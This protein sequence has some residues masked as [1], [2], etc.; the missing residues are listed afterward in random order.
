MA[1]RMKGCQALILAVLAAALGLA[2][3]G[4]GGGAGSDPASV[5]PP[6]APLFVEATL[7]PEGQQ[8]ADVDALAKKIAGIDDL[9]E[10]IVEELEKKATSSDEEFDFAKE[11]E[12]WLGERG[13][14]SF[15]EYDGEDF[16]GYGIAVQTE[17]TG[18][19]EAFLA[20][21]EKAGGESARSASYEGVDYEVQEDGTSIGVIEGFLAVAETEA[22][23]KAM[24]RASDGDSLAD[25]ESYANAVSAAPSD[26][27]ASAYVDV[28]G[29]IDQAGGSIDPKTR[30]F[31]ETAGIEPRN[32]TATASL[33][34]GSDTVEIDLTTDLVEGSTPD[35]RVSEVL[36]ALPASSF[37]AIASTEFGK[38]FGEA[39]D[40]I[41]ADG[42]QGQVPPHKFK[43][44]LKAAGIDLE[45]I[46]ASVTDLG[47][48]AEGSSRS[49]LRVAAVLTTKDAA[50]ARRTVSG[51]GF[52]VRASGTP[53]VTAVSGR[54]SGFSVPDPELGPKPLA[55]VSKGDRIAIGYGLAAAL[56]GVSGGPGPTL[57]EDP[58]FKEA[59]AALGDTP[60][61]GFADGPAALR[62]A[63]SLVSPGEEDF[64][65][66][67]PYLS[68]IE[69]LALG[70]GASDGLATVKLIAG[71]GGRE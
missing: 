58:T 62:L 54:A 44:T 42:I 70:S 71:I 13:G 20:R 60:I 46:S 30:L 3:C 21:R 40:Q 61:D 69:Y 66:A 37:A 31:L 63:S 1:A 10:F 32:A 49:S 22:A 68:K 39:I 16:S 36:G 28:G 29:L 43:S 51:I 27:L 15:E 26:A 33:V 50:E 8:K 67:K 59:A 2:G 34:P 6:D 55:V 11:V 4:G 38:R 7:R 47:V 5:A 19:T 57:A 9:G 41:D 12:P 14:I 52:L 53:G 25:R 18:A 23:F 64:R 65:K 48:F 45:K 56:R 17:D 24:V 35:S